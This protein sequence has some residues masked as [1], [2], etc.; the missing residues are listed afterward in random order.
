MAQ[1]RRLPR[2]GGSGSQEA[3]QTGWDGMGRRHGIS[4]ATTPAAKKSEHIVN[5]PRLGEPA[6]K[7][8]HKLNKSHQKDSEIRLSA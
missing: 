3:R 1:G 8:E 6:K 7:Q 5:A 2:T 4:W